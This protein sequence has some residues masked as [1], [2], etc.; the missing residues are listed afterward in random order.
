MAA[1]TIASGAVLGFHGGSIGASHQRVWEVG[2]NLY[3]V[4]VETAD[5][6]PHVY[7]STDQA[8]TWAV[9]DAAN[10]PD[11]ENTLDVDRAFDSGM[12]DGDSII[13]VV[14][15]VSGSNY[16]L[17]VARFDTS[18]DLWTSSLGNATNTVVTAN[19]TLRENVR[20][21]IRS[22]GDVIVAFTS[23]SDLSDIFYSR[24]EGSWTSDVAVLDAAG[25]G[26]SNVLD[27]VIDSADRCYFFYLNEQLDDVYYRS[28]SSAN[29]LETAVAIDTA[30]SSGLDLTFS[31]RYEIYDVGGTDTITLAFNN[32]TD[33]IDANVITLESASDAGNVSAQESS[34]HTGKNLGENAIATFT[35]SG[36]R[37]IFWADR[38]DAD[39]LYISDSGSGWGTAASNETV[40]QTL[41]GPTVLGFAG[42]LLGGVYVTWEDNGAVYGDWFIAPP[43]SGTTINGGH[44]SASA[45]AFAGK[46][47]IKAKGSLATATAAALA[48]T[49]D[50]LM[51]GAH[52]LA[53][54]AANAGTVT[55]D[56]SITEAHA[57]ATAAA[58]AG[59]L[60]IGVPGSH[61]LADAE[62]F[63]GSVGYDLTILGSHAL[64]DAVANAG[65]LGLDLVGSLAL[66]SATAFGGSVGNDSV[67]DGGHASAT[68]AGNAGR[69]SILL[70]GSHATA[71]AAALAGKPT[72]AIKGSLAE[73]SA[74]AFGGAVTSDSGSGDDEDWY[75][76][77][78]QLRPR[79]RMN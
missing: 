13:Y 53:D 57:T 51:R 68:A 20:I 33:D 34:I 21:A 46:P 47:T 11:G 55:Y 77:I 41:T 5:G 10:A 42:N 66:A 31:A 9:Q 35:H 39:I 12:R 69:M 3:K 17:A 76:D 60:D 56:S 54:A 28:L 71:D 49:V 64:A 62:A 15:R 70:D 29:S 45:A 26:F 74:A 36:T 61:A 32:S 67:I 24:Y 8:A 2:G 75:R 44:A 16:T 43:A 38:D 48:G 63:G 65:L 22:D 59:L 18:T 30:A 72:V 73:G 23:S 25:A 1:V 19:E 4:V 78:F 40:W 52:A 50:I 37:Y 7:K 58:N 27:L 14:Y 79:R 6:D